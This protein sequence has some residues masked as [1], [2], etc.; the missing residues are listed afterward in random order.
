MLVESYSTK[1]AEFYITRLPDLIGQYNRWIC[2][3]NTIGWVQKLDKALLEKTIQEKSTKIDKYHEV[4]DNV[5][6]L[7]VIDRI[8]HSGMMEWCTEGLCCGYGFTSVYIHFF[9]FETYKVS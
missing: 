4:I 5:I 8:R 2:M 3:N 9:P 6:L 1:Y 7:M